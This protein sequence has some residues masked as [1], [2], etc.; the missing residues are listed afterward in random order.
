[1]NCA[2]FEKRNPLN[3]LHLKIKTRIYG[4]R[5]HQKPDG[6][7]GIVTLLDGVA[8][9]REFGQKR[10]QRRWCCWRE[11]IL[12]AEE[13]IR[14]GPFMVVEMQGLGQVRLVQAP[15]ETSG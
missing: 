6:S 14:P 4:V 9:S 3:L 13:N 12:L 5:A 1:M 11:A 15:L 2:R 10:T 7:G 8:F